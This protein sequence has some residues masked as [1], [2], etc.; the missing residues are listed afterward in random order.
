MVYIGSHLPAKTEAGTPEK[1]HSLHKGKYH[2]TADLLFDWFRFSCFAY[3]YATAD[4]LVRP[5]SNQTG[6][7]Q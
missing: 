7:Q 1:A 6:G 4:L 5:N 2:C 3:V